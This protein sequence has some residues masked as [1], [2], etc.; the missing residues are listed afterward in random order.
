VQRL[1]GDVGSVAQMP[2][3]LAGQGNIID[4]A[5]GNKH[6]GQFF[7]SLDKRCRAVGTPKRCKLAA[8]N[9]FG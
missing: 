3:Q 4:G 1:I 6:R 2:R 9:W 7:V 8:N 5:N